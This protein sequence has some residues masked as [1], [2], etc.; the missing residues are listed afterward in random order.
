VEAALREKI[1]KSERR[2]ADV[3][4]KLDHLSADEQDVEKK[5]ERRRR[6]YEQLQ[7]R[8]GESKSSSTSAFETL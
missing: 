5:I 3:R 8:L 6:E 7:K 4:Y 2:I 1:E